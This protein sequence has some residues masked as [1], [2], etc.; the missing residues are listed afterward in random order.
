MNFPLSKTQHSNTGCAGVRRTPLRVGELSMISVIVPTLNE[1]GNLPR[2]LADLSRQESSSEILVVDGG[3]EDNTVS[4]AREHGADVI[5]SAP[6]RGL[7][8]RRGAAAATGDVLLFLHAD[9]AFPSGGL[10]RI[11][12]VLAASPQI[13]GGNFRLLFDGDSDFSRWL[14]G[15]YAWLRRHGIYYGDSG[16]FVRREAYGALGGL[17]SIALMEDYDFT[18]RLERFGETFCIEDPPLVTSSRRFQGRRPL[19]IVYGWLKIHAL[20]HLGVSPE[21]L[22]RMYDSARRRDRSRAPSP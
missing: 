21:R 3:S 9:S 4:L 7:Q 2:L 5:R 20:F 19:Q 11:E 1:A 6:G 14:T 22:A 15:F 12:T 13:V 8:L 18:R 17:R 10:A 16:V